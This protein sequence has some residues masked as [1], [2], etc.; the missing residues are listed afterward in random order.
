VGAAFCPHR[1]RSWGVP[2]SRLWRRGFLFGSYEN[3]SDIAAKGAEDAARIARLFQ[4]WEQ[5]PA[6]VLLPCYMEAGVQV[7]HW[8]LDKANRLLFEAQKPA[9]IGDGEL[10]S[11]W[12]TT[13]APRLRSHGQPVMVNGRMSLGD[14][15]RLGPNAL[16]DKD[17][18]DRA[19][20][21]LSPHMMD[22]GFHLRLEVHGRRRE[23]VLNPT[24]LIGRPT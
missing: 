11:E 12:L 6:P 1:H 23:L 24:L 10:L 20:K 4:V 16:R 2:T 19:L 7:A 8:Y 13:V 3:V 18:R 22:D 15:L 9:E 14:I 21:L 5:G 17:R